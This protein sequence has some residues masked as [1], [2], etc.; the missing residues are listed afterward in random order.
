MISGVQKSVREWTL[1]FSS[2]LPFWEL[3]SQWIAKFSESNFKDQITLI[4]KILYIIRKLLEQDVWNGL[5]WPIWTLKIKVMA[6]RK[7]RN[8]IGNLT[9]EH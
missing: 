8:Q 3:K 1:T 9:S 5:S 4:W 2:E 7:V 6:K